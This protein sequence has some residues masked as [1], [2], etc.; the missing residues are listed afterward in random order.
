M[1]N[2]FV[3]V[4]GGAKN[5]NFN[6]ILILDKYSIM[7]LMQKLKFMQEFALAMNVECLCSSLQAKLQMHNCAHAKKYFIV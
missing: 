2:I 3:D 6:I 4:N 1:S 5:H 7:I